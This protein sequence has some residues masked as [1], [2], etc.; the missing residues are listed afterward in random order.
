MSKATIVSIMPI[1]INFENPT[2]HPSVYSIP[3]NKTRADFQVLVITDAS[4]YVYLDD[5]R[6]HKPSPIPALELALSLVGD[7]QRAS[8]Q[9]SENAFP[10][11][12]VLDGEFT[13]KQVEDDFED[14]LDAL[15]SFQENWLM[16]IIAEADDLW[17]KYRQHRVITGLA[18][19]AA[20]YLGFDREWI[21]VVPE[22]E[23]KCPACAKNV[24]PTAVICANC[25]FILDEKKYKTMKFANASSTQIGEAVKA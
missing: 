1:Q 5:N 14:R 20:Q 10:G 11:L 18:R 2:V 21:T 19:T 25:N 17:S 4:T 9:V 7:Y 23:K 8:I 22:I 13:R 6:G 16:K 15:R 12:L 24:N 3:A